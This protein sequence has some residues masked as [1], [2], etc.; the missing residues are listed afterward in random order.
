MS[1]SAVEATSSSDANTNS[2]H[3]KNLP[4]CR[5]HT[6]LPFTKM[7][8]DIASPE[9]VKEEKSLRETRGRR[10]V[11]VLARL[12]EETSVV[13]YEVKVLIPSPDNAFTFL[14]SFVAVTGSRGGC[15]GCR[16]RFVDFCPRI[17]CGVFGRRR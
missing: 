7:A 6:Y 2:E 14:V 13:E 8:R 17:E 12:A 5:P 11:N 3:C 4:E 10:T 15:S 1:I 9:A 16:C